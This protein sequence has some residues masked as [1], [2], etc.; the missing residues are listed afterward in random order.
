MTLEK[1]SARLA[2]L[3]VNEFIRLELDTDIDK[4]AGL[5]ADVPNIVTEVPV[6]RVYDDQADKFYDAGKLLAF[7][8]TLDLGAASLDPDST[9]NIWQLMDGCTL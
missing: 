8:K 2:D 1:Q 3:I 6:V 9:D 7:L 4:C 5:F